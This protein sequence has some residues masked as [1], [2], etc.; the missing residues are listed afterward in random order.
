VLWQQVAQELVGVPSAELGEPG[1]PGVDVAV[2]RAGFDEQQEQV[3]LVLAGEGRRAVTDALAEVGRQAKADI[4]VPALAALEMRMVA[5][6]DD[7]VEGSDQ[8][9]G[10]LGV[11]GLL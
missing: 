6:V 8:L 7:D 4:L 10:G 3:V 2:D 1:E 11:V 9:V 5:A